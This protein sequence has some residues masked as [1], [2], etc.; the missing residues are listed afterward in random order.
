MWNLLNRFGTEK[1]WAAGAVIVL[2]VLAVIGS[3]I[4]AEVKIGDLDPGAPEL[5]PNSRYNKDNAFLNANYG[6]SSDQFAV[7]VKTPPEGCL[8]YE[9]LVE[10]DRLVD[11]LRGV[12]GVQTVGA[13]PDAARVLI[14]SSYEG[15]LKWYALTRNQSELNYGVGTARD[16]NND[17][18]NN[19][20]TVMPVI[21]YLKDHRADTLTSVVNVA[22]EFSKKHSTKNREF[23]LAAGNSG[24]DAATNIVVK[25]ENR[26]MM[27]YVYLAVI[28]LCYITFRNWR[29]VVVAVIP[30][31]LTSIL[32]EA[33]M[34]IL[35]IGVK[36]AT[37][38]VIALGVGIGV[39]YALYL[40]TVQLMHMRNGLSLSEAYKRSV[41]F[42][43]KVVALVGITLASAVVTWAWSPIK[44]QAD[45]GLLLSFMFF[46]NMIGALIFI[47][48]LSRFI[49][50]GKSSGTGE[51]FLCGLEKCE[52]E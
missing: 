11:E 23:L 43:G 16:N 27:I 46:Y 26:I 33:L 35:G 45:M 25:R 38:P 48:A 20:A 28:A 29:A 17:L 9:T 21:A 14:S 2:V 12:P 5:R 31:I 18:F 22:D 37:L 34:V 42:T 13:L 50:C 51:V 52:K 49:L 36:V 8:K 24:I 41:R 3:I 30:L 4:G 1:K 39:D 40:L 44:F 6:L 10:V 47:P 19:E 7:I 32:C 15:S